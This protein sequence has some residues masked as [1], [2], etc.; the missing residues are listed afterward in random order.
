[1]KTSTLVGHGTVTST[2]S[3]GSANQIDCG[4][5]CSVDFAYGTVVTLT[6]TPAFLSL[7]DGWTDCDSASGTTCTVTMTSARTVTA[8]FLP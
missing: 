2:S 3:P 7:F 6:A 5:T 4:P 1:M 8:R